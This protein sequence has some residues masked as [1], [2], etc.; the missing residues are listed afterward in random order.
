MHIDSFQDAILNCRF[1]FMC[2]H[3][4]A[5][6]NVRSTEADTPRVRAAM[7]YGLTTG[8]NALTDPDFVDSLYRNDLSG[9]CRRNCV[10]H[11]DEV[12][13]A[14]AAR[15]DAVDAGLAPAAVAA[16]AGKL[17]KS[18]A[19][20]AS[21]SGSTAVFVDDATAEA[22]TVE[23]ALAKLLKKA[24]VAHKTLRGG[25]IGKALAVL[26]YPERAKACAQAFA[27]FLKAEGV[28]T[29]VCPNPAAFDAL[30]RD[31]PAWGVKLP[32][33]VVCSANFL[34]GAKLSFD[35]AGE[36]YYLHS[37]F[38]RNYDECECPDRLL[39]ALQAVV[40]PFGTNDEESYSCGEGAVVFDRLQP[41]LAK[42]LA[43][44]VAA[45]ADNPKTDTLV[46]SSPYT[47][48]VLRKHT[49]L[50]VVS[51]EELAASLLR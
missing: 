4:S 1:C 48:R 16:L 10:K 6:G 35:K 50:N 45:R 46:V 36:V 11:F 27:D 15:A 14:L 26:G 41:A 40:K 8:T 24:R 25:C 38:M 13:L 33:K 29:L 19:W 12:G 18:A 39:A 37:D 32:C 51:L 42:Q 22:K 49:R 43:A 20:T 17:E 28:K 47:L 5:I 31:F 3:L 7:I 34:L 9:A 2:R 23:P 44:Y 21:G 30:S